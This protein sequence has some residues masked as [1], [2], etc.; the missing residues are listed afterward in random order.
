MLSTCTGLLPSLASLSIL[1]QFLQNTYWPDPRSLVTTSGV[2][3]D[4][5]SSGY[6]DISVRRVC[7]TKL[8]IHF[9]IPIN[10]WVPP[11]RNLRIKGCSH[12]PEAYRSVLRLSSPSN[13]KA[14]T[15]CPYILKLLELHFMQKK[16]YITISASLNL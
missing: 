15:K 9:A 14:S 10:R 13:A 16:F 8:F 3:F 4:F 12:L 2:S 6:L 7:L 1:F 11:F 5:F